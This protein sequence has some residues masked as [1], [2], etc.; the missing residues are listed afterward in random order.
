MGKFE[1][2]KEKWR[3]FTQKK[4]PGRAQNES[5]LEKTGR[6][7]KVTGHYLYL[8]RKVFLSIPVVY[9]SVR[10]ALYSNANLPEKVGIHLQANGEFAEMISRSSAVWGPVAVTSACLLM[11]FCSRRALYPWLI[12]LFSLVLPILILFTAGLP[13]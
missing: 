7:L 2:A 6:I 3:G 8:L 12:S 13:V 9:G 11:M 1:N 5:A 10:L 4:R